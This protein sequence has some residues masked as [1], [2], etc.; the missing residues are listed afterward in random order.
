M[1]SPSNVHAADGDS[2]EA[3][4]RQKLFVIIAVVL[5]II[6]ALEIAVLFMPIIDPVRIAMLVVFSI[7][8]FALVIFIFM[9]LRWDRLFCTILFLTGLSLAGGT[10]TILLKVFGSKDSIPLTSHASITAPA[11]LDAISRTA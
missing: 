2:H 7:I 8:K 1:S 4:K 10:V 6:T 11:Q 9:H 3:H 5:G